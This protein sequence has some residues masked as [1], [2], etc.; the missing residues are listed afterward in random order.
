MKKKENSMIHRQVYL[1][2]RVKS[3]SYF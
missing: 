2:S 1:M 3:P